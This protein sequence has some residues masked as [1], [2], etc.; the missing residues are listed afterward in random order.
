MRGL[1]IALINFYKKFIS[2]RKGFACAHRVLHGGTSC[3]SYV[4]EQVEIHGLLKAMALTKAR[5]RS[6][7]LAAKTLR[8]EN[9][10]EGGDKNK[11]RRKRDGAGDFLDIDCCA[12][13]GGM[14]DTDSCTPDFD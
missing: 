1:V 3:S 8:A 14:P 11:K 10:D 4:R 5:F 9:N 13:A 6:C 2:P 12:G 7:A